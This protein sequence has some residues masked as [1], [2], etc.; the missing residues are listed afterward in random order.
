MAEDFWLVK[1]SLNADSDSEPGSARQS[2]YSSGFTVNTAITNPTLV[3]LG[4]SADFSSVIVVKR[5]AT[6]VPMHLGAVALLSLAVVVSAS[7]C[8]ATKSYT[9]ATPNL[10]PPKL[11]QRA[12]PS[13]TDEAR[14][15][16]ITGNVEFLVRIG[17]D[18]KPEDV[19]VTKSLD[20]VHGL[21]DEA[22]SAVRRFVFSPATLNGRP[23]AVDDVPISL[24]FG[25]Y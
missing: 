23:V 19:R 20:K 4:R 8:G 14:R 10:V 15:A 22:I 3:F 21:D 2:R 16:H 13:Y 7:G 17:A 6:E 25:V 18:G 5:P 9:L 11:I 24:S 12:T 1:P